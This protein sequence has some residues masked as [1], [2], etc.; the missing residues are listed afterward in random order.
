MGVHPSHGHNGISY[1][2]RT[3]YLTYMRVD[4]KHNS[5]QEFIQDRVNRESYLE[6][7][8]Y[9][10]PIKQIQ[11]KRTSLLA[12]IEKVFKSLIP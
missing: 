2:Y 5:V 9:E 7:E 11:K 10:R 4:W 8:P 1:Y 6:C 12:S 3:N